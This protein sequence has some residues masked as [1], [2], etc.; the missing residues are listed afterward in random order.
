VDEAFT[1]TALEVEHAMNCR[2]RMKGRAGESLNQER[3]RERERERE[4]WL[5]EYLKE[6]RAQVHGESRDNSYM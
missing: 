6:R 4:G 2:C 1:K 3:E 5:H